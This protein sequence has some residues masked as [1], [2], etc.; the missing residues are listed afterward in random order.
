[1][2]RAA[3]VSVVMASGLLAGCNRSSDLGPVPEPPAGYPFAYATRDCA[4]WD[5]PAVTVYFAAVESEQ[6]P[7]ADR[8]LE[9]S[10]YRS[11]TDLA[12]RTFGWPADPEVGGGRRCL[13][14]DTCE[15][16]PEGRVSIR[17]SRPDSSL[18]GELFLRTASGDTVR[19]GFNA[20]WRDRRIMCG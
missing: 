18:A 1:M 16:V 20:R 17:E 7:P 2:H 15:V 12:G 6:I 8:H 3:I 19:G 4:P 9:V 5:G 14:A 13:S 11:P 10:I